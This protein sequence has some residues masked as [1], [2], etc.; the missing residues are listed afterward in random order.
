VSG[1]VEIALSRR[2]QLQ[3]EHLSNSRQGVIA[4]GTY[5]FNR[6]IGVELAADY[7]LASGNTSVRSVSVGPVYRFPLPAHFTAYVHVLGGAAEIVGPEFPLYFGLPFANFQSHPG[8]T[9]WRAA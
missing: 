9:S 8:S 4:S 6:N 7:H 3:G 2:D 1:Q 5:S